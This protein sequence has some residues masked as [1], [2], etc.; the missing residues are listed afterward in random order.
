MLFLILKNYLFYIYKMNNSQNYNTTE[1]SN[2]QIPDKQYSDANEIVALG[3]S[4]DDIAQLKIQMKIYV[5]LFLYIQFK[6]NKKFNNSSSSGNSMNRL[7]QKT[8][9]DSMQSY[10]EDMASQM[11]LQSVDLFFIKPLFESMC[12]NNYDDICIQYFNSII[13]PKQD[14]DH[15]STNDFLEQILS[16]YEKFLGDYEKL[17]ENESY[18]AVANYVKSLKGNLNGQE[19]AAL[20][21]KMKI[22]VAK[23]EQARQSVD[24]SQ[25]ANAV[26]SV[27][28][29]KDADI[30]READDAKN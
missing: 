19:L 9:I 22:D 23:V 5:R 10:K 13:K 21:N 14:I 27:D 28:V 18:K 4:N 12:K 16:K 11:D 1:Y 15:N 6:L 2:I 24:D 17:E 29:I 7:T 20:M 26:D 30:A 3:P 25:S 8:L